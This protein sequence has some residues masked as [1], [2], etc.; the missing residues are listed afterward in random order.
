M[1]RMQKQCLDTL[2]DIVQPKTIVRKPYTVLNCLTDI[3]GSCMCDY[4]GWV[5]VYPTNV[6]VTLNISLML[7]ILNVVVCVMSH[8]RGEFDRFKP[9]TCLGL[10]PFNLLFPIDYGFDWILCRY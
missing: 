3:L 5:I 4:D 10:R 7:T 9:K 2:L 1:F 8:N 6:P